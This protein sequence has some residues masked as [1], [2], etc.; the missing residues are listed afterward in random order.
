MHHSELFFE[1][2]ADLPK[3]D[4][5]KALELSIDHRKEELEAA[6]QFNEGIIGLQKQ[7]L[8]DLFK[9]IGGDRVKKYLQL[10]S[11]RIDKIRRIYQSYPHTPENMEKITELRKKIIE[12]SN[13]VINESGV[14]ADQVKELM[15]QSH[16][17]AATLFTQTIGKGEEGKE[18]ERVKNTDYFPPYSGWGWSYVW[19]RSDEPDM[20]TFA[21][22]LNHRTGE[23][24]TYSYIQVIGA[25]N[26]D[27]A[28]VRYRVALAQWHR[29][30]RDTPRIYVNADIDR[31]N[32]PYWGS[33]SDECG[34]SGVS[35]RQRMCFYA[36]IISPYSTPHTYFS[37]ATP[38]TSGA[39]FDHRNLP[40]TLDDRWSST[41]FPLRSTRNVEIGGPFS[42]SDW[43]CIHFGIETY[44]YFWSND[45]TVTSGMDQHY[46]I[47]RIGITEA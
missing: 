5:W 6:K 27:L 12:G 10:H 34:I 24:G 43:I 41:H 20:P 35:F 46:M 9:I 22:F 45:V 32:T 40:R 26:S 7:Y 28:Y 23:I 42:E 36:R 13:K 30:S 39:G 38:H 21:R 16:D 8:D 19:Q 2:N 31:V 47:N 37:V 1:P 3:K 4:Y 15:K 25:D 44:N 29:I 18:V 33:T 14:N 17:K 11:E